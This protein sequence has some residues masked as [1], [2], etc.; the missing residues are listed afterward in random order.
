MK[1][2]DYTIPL[3]IALFL[4]ACLV[5]CKNDTPVKIAHTFE[6]DDTKFYNGEILLPDYVHL[7]TLIVIDAKLLNWC[8]EKYDIS[9]DGDINDVLK[10]TTKK[11]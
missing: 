2:A 6:T 7:D 9:S 5:S 4:F 10:I 1:K 8:M 11:L 3:L